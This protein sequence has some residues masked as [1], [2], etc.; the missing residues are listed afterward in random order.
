MTPS[1]GLQRAL[2]DGCSMAFSTQLSRGGQA[3]MDGLLKGKLLPGIKSFKVGGDM[4]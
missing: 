3:V 2:L 1:Y 4:L